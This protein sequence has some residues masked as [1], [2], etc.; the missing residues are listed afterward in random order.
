MATERVAFARFIP[1]SPRKL[2]VPTA[3]RSMTIMPLHERARPVEQRALRQQVAGRCHA[4]VVR[5]RGQVEDLVGAAEARSRPARPT[6]GRRQP[7]VDRL[8][9]SATRA[10]RAPNGAMRPRRSRRCGAGS[11]DVRRQ[12]LEAGE[13]S[14]RPRARRPR[15]CR[16]RTPGRRRR[17]RPVRTTSSSTTGAVAPSPSGR[18][19]RDERPIGR[20]AP[21][22]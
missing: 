21:S 12:L 14:V 22:G 16:R 15:A 13:R 3:E 9:T 8:R 2:S 6:I 1:N 7:V 10:G 17:R 18:S 11:D 19:V 20:P 4:D 5:V